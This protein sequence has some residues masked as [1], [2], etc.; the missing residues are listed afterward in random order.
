V[1]R[2]GVAVNI[3]RC[4]NV[5][6]S[7]TLAL[8]EDTS[9]AI[10]IA[11]AKQLVDNGQTFLAAGPV[12]RRPA[13]IILGVHV[14]SN[15]PKSSNLCQVVLQNRIDQFFVN[16]FDSFFLGAMSML[17]IISSIDGQQRAALGDGC[18][19]LEELSVQF[20]VPCASGNDFHVTVPLNVT[21]SLNHDSRRWR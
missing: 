5:R 14:S 3:L 12:K 7:S 20:L 16:A 13:E 17:F 19:C 10:A 8:A 18:H 2:S 21:L 1:Q 15:T 4:F 6:S 11:G 9:C